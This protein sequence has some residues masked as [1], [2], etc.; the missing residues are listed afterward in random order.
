MRRVLSTLLVAALC[1]PAPAAACIWEYG[2]KLDGSQVQVDGMSRRMRQL[3]TFPPAHWEE[4]LKENAAKCNTATAHEPCNDQA[5]ALMYLGRA[6]EAIGLLQEIEKAHPG[7]YQTA[8]N[9]GT[10][11]E[12]AGDNAAALKWISEGI[13]RNP[14]SH[15][16]TEWLHVRILEAKIA[17]SADPG[18]LRVHSPLDG[19]PHGPTGSAAQPEWRQAG[20]VDPAG[21]ALQQ[22]E[23]SNAIRYQLQERLQ[24]VKPPESIVGEL[25]LEMGSILALK[26]TAETALP[27]LEQ[28]GTFQP[29]RADLLR[30]RTALVRKVV[31]G[32]P[33]SGKRASGGAE[34]PD[35]AKYVVFGLALLAVFALYWRS[36][37]KRRRE[38]GGA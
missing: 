27:V 18:W 28:A 10:A 14:K 11:H 37:R 25:L 31:A 4:R 19:R 34:I 5:V 3:R 6:P 29:A 12:L 26:E 36:R 23:V 16:G 22:D 20:V 17:L 38:A 9:L 7:A 35:S 21:R 15:D 24:F 13:R 2:T 32:N 8:V 33:Q 1:S 30:D